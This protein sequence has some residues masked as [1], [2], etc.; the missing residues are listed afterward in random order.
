MVT[1]NKTT[2]VL[3]PIQPAR[4]ALFLT[5]LGVLI[6]ISAVAVRAAESSLRANPVKPTQGSTLAT[7][8]A[9]SVTTEPVLSQPVPADVVADHEQHVGPGRRVGGAEH[10][11]RN[12]QQSGQ[13][14]N[15]VFH[16]FLSLVGDQVS[17]GT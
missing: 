17:V 12:E 3:K 8:A 16:E 5:V 4:V 11:D 1:L 15:P 10:A 9:A 6:A 7:Q 2:Q 13:C 14:E